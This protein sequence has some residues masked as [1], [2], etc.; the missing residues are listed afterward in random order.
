MI[1][2]L[3]LRFNFVIENFNTTIILLPIWNY[4]ILFV[5]AFLTVV[6]PLNTR[7]YYFHSRYLEKQKKR[8]DQ[9]F[10]PQCPLCEVVSCLNHFALFIVCIVCSFHSISIKPVKISS[11]LSYYVLNCHWH[12]SPKFPPLKY[13]PLVDSCIWTTHP[14][15]KSAISLISEDFKAIC[16][17]TTHFCLM[18]VVFK[19]SNVT[20]CN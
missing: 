1:I 20:D 6:F 9:S 18:Q 3:L 14:T 10:L 19:P 2:V 4:S 15:H 13:V 7:L 11:H 5:E 12:Q 16:N 8:W 17:L